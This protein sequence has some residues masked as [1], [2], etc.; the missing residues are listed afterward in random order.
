MELGII[1]PRDTTVRDAKLL[2]RFLSKLEKRL[3][4]QSASKVS[5]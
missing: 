3:K 2:N 1:G 4:T 5:K